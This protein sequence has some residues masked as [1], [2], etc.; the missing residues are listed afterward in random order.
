MKKMYLLIIVML[1]FVPNLVSANSISN[2]SM[3][4]Y[5]DNNGN[6]HVKEVWDTYLNEGTEG[7]KPYYNLGESIISN[8]SVSMDGKEFTFQ[9]IW[10]VDNSFDDKKY[11]N[12]FNY[13]EDGVE[14]CF[15][16]SEYGSNTYTLNYDISN[17]VVNTSD[18]YQMIYWTLFPYDYNPSPSRVYIKIYS[19][20]KYSNTLDVWGYGKGGVP[21]Y[22][23]DG[24]IEMDS[25]TRVNSDEYMTILV[26][27]PSNTFN[28]NV[29]MNKTFNDYFDM[30]EEGAIPY[31]KPDEIISDNSSVDDSSDDIED[32]IVNIIYIIWIIS[33]CC[34]IFIPAILSIRNT[35]S[36]A[37][38]ELNL[39]KIDFGTK[40]NKLGKVS[41]YRQLPYKKEELYKV[42]WFAYQ[43]N[44]ISVS[45]DYF[46]AIL[47]KWLKLGKISLTREDN[48]RTKK[49]NDYNV[50]IIFHDC[51]DLEEKERELYSM[52]Y[53]ASRDGILKKREFN[54]WCNSHSTEIWNWFVSVINDETERLVSEGKLVRIGKRNK[55]SVTDDIYLEAEKIAGIK[56]FLNDF[57]NIKDRSAF[58]VH[59]WQE[60][61]MYAQIFGIA[62][63]VMKEFKKLYPDVITDEDYDNFND[64]Y[65]VHR[66]MYTFSRRSSKG[67]FSSYSSGGGGYSSSGGG[68]GSFGGG[69]GGG[70]GFR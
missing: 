33:M 66:R 55:Y 17:F 11:H 27:F 6:A 30:A 16:I 20:F 61:L 31:E 10:N 40:G 45:T 54:A 5:V 9:D 14:L 42:Y 37:S 50:S 28:L 57:S 2:I 38:R 3:E 8:F 62:K 1:L 68:R 69:R 26:K 24:Y 19:D 59:L 56:R 12:G 60:Y 29:T 4:I 22:V 23:Y 48:T 36:K 41:Y 63:K 47:L 44:L 35:L 52:M 43:Y 70:G 49:K 67:S 18:E 25:E 34:L 7:Y 51:I 58:E 53:K 65:H 13:V 39:Y 21:T 32:M 64:I 46:G 15:G